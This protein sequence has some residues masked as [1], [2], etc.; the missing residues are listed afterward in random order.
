MRRPDFR[1]LTS[2]LLLGVLAGC[3]QDVPTRLRGAM[4]V[5]IEVVEERATST[6]G[7]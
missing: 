5:P 3:G 1:V 2:A 6:A 7:R 4:A